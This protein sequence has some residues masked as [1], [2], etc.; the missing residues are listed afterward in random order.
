MN[1]EN[2]VVERPSFVLRQLKHPYYPGRL[3]IIVLPIFLFGCVHW[4]D[5]A[6]NCEA[7]G[8]LETHDPIAHFGRIEPLAADQ[9]ELRCASIKETATQLN[10]GA[11]IKGCVVLMA[12]GS[13]SAYYSEGDTCAK[14][15]ELCHILHGFE[16]TASY[17]E[18]ASINHP[19]PYC[20][21]NQLTL[22][23]RAP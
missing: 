13:V 10:P 11:T 17:L 9:L 5:I 19:R 12:D 18:K 6:S 20:P 4:P 21:E 15:H 16:H 3:L 14:N 8:V 23:V 1:W 7:Y 2:G 22:L